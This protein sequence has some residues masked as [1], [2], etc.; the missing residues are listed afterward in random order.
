MVGVARGDTA[1]AR[2]AD[3][4]PGFDLVL[5]DLRLPG[6]DGL[7]VLE[8]AL[9]RDPRTR[10]LVMTAY[11]SVETAV[12]AMRRGAFDFLE[13]PVDLDQLEVRVQRA[14]EHRALLDEVGHLRAE[15]AGRR[16]TQEIIGA[17]GSLREATELALRVAPTRSTVLVTGETGT[18]KELV[19]EWIHRASDRRDGPLVKVNCAALPE[20][21]LESE[22]F[23]HERGAFTGAD[24]QRIGRFEEASGARCSS[25]R[26]ATSPPASRPSCCACC[27]T[28][29]STAWAARGR[30]APTRGSWRRPTM[31]SRRPSARGASERTCTSDSTS[32]RS[33]C[34]RLR[35]RPDDLLPLARHFLVTLPH[36]GPR[37]RDL[38]K[39]A[40]AKL[41]A[42]PW[43]GN[44]RELRNAI[45]RALLLASGPRIEASDL[46]LREPLRAIG[47]AGIPPEWTLADAER[48]LVLDALERT[49][50]VQKDASER[51]GV[52]RRKLNY[53]IRRMGITHPSWRRN[54]GPDSDR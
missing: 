45:E 37:P 33:G 4:E 8:A 49:G 7:A 14:A 11:G 34:L 50:Y 23:G 51:L 10:V 26:W 25:T 16:A 52:S 21:L 1:I 13:K 5:T 40:C 17:K 38:S 30:C 20:P 31:T 29:S 41:E 6:A 42:H 54:R 47:P 2:L 19:A 18:G 12:E 39:S 15:R 22:L 44:V 36:D 28:R 48:A 53:M 9:A 24:R 43:P 3:A 46:A 27:R 32:S 35:D